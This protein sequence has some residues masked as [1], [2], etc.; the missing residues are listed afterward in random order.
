MRQVAKRHTRTHTQQ[1]SRD[2]NEKKKEQTELKLLCT[3]QVSSSVLKRHKK[4]RQFARFTSFGF[5]LCI[6]NCSYEQ[7]ERSESCNENVITSTTSSS[8]DVYHICHFC[9]C[10]CGKAKS[11]KRTKSNEWQNAE[12]ELLKNNKRNGEKKKTNSKQ[13]KHRHIR[14]VKHTMN[15]Q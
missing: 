8:S 14:G 5:S 10:M 7:D 6:W 9:V 3:Q 1:K 11:N 15:T 13:L 4:Q 2:S 12:W